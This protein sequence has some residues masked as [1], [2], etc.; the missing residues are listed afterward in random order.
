MEKVQRFVGEKEVSKITGRAVQTL[1]NDRAK[2]QG[3]PY[4]KLGR[5][6]RY[7]LEDVLAYMEARKIRVDPL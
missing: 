3:I 6:V 1:R 2:R 4:S 7:S 5:L